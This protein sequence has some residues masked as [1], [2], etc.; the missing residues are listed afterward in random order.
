MQIGS[1]SATNSPDG[2]AGISFECRNADYAE[3]SDELAL[4]PEI[5]GNM[6]RGARWFSISPYGEVN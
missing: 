3:I 1:E 4:Q 6:E 2:V 5:R